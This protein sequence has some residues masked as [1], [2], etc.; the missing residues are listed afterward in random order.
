MTKHWSRIEWLCLLL[1]FPVAAV[2]IEVA[3]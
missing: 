3:K 2:L 1:T